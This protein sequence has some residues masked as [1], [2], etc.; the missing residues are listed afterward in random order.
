MVACTFG[1]QEASEEEIASGSPR[2]TLI[3]ITPPAQPN[4]AAEMRERA[5]LL[6]REQI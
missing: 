3:A 4:Q 5:A 6:V 2:V 1:R